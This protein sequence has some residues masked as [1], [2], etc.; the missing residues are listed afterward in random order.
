MQQCDELHAL[1]NT[2]QIA[3]QSA[4]GQLTENGRNRLRD[5]VKGLSG[6]KLHVLIQKG[7]H[8]YPRTLE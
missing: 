1:A 5:L 8:D 4:K 6:N 3:L 7:K 2:L